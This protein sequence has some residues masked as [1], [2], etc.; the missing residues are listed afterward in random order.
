MGVVTLCAEGWSR[1]DPLSV[2]PAG[3]GCHVL[4]ASVTAAAWCVVVTSAIAV[5]LEVLAIGP[6]EL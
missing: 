2:S 6:G 4:E 3:E 5:S 1:G